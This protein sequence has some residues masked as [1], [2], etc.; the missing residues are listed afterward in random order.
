MIYLVF[1]EIN[2][3]ELIP[4]E[5]KHKDMSVKKDHILYILFHIRPKGKLFLKSHIPF[6]PLNVTVGSINRLHC[7]W[8]SI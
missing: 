7:F 3:R 2:S 1:E 8:G 4:L 5:T 6:R